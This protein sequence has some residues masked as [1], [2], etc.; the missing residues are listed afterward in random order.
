[1][2]QQDLFS[3][4]STINNVMTGKAPFQELQSNK[5]KELYKANEFPDMT[6]LLYEDITK[7][8]WNYEIASAQ[9]V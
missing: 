3:F 9:E 1:M 2:I 8:C 5:V 4:G 7:Q 6:G